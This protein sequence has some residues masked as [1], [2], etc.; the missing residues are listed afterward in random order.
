MRI[1]G[2]DVGCR[3]A[4][5][6][7]NDVHVNDENDDYEDDDLDLHFRTKH[8]RIRRRPKRIARASVASFHESTRFDWACMWGSE[9]AIKVTRW[10]RQRYV[11]RAPLWLTLV[12]MP[13][14]YPLIR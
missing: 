5:L 8:A 3:V 12:G 9:F 10:R 11:T 1:H 7:A 6:L 2:G 13:R 14:T 4:T